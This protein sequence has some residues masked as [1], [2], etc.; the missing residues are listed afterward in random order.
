MLC[1]TLV[2][3]ACLLLAPAVSGVSIS[4]S[5]STSL[6]VTDRPIVNTETQV[7][8][9]VYE[10][11]AFTLGDMVDNRLSFEGSLR[12]W[13]DLKNEADDKADVRL[14]RA[15]F[16]WYDSA[17]G[18]RID[19][20]RQ[21][22]I[23]GVGRTYLDGLL[24][25]Q[26][27]QIISWSVFFGQP[28][29]RGYHKLSSWDELV[30]Q[31]GVRTQA[32]ISSNLT[33]DF[34]Y[35][36]MQYDG[37]LGR[38]LI[39]VSSQLRSGSQ[40]TFRTRI[41]VDVEASD[42]DRASVLW[43]FSPGLRTIYTGELQ[44]RQPRLWAFS[45]LEEIESNGYYRA[46]IGM[47]R[48]VIENVRLSIAGSALNVGSSAAGTVDVGISW[49]TLHVGYLFVSTNSVLGH[50]LYVRGSYRVSSWIT[51]GGRTALNRYEIDHQ[52]DVSETI[53]SALFLTIVPVRRLE[54]TG[55][56]HQVTNDLYAYQLEGLISVRYR[57]E[58]L[59]G[60]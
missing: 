52:N 31:W 58:K 24:V 48:P 27:R 60:K 5:S 30:F 29:R 17:N 55:E 39:G 36:E 19:G 50:G 40:H 1:Y 57:F 14:Y 51:L 11:L 35:T 41:D 16:R 2:L 56:I 47:V 22:I 38:R 45:A 46:T 59:S 10:S 4:G 21:F 12:G 7:R 42:L 3:L 25:K 6:L 26:R 23:E 44:Y 8:I 43:T 9:P 32:R 28:L 13:R 15:C 34:S 37:D 54:L 18:I 20:G 49:N 53:G 33:L